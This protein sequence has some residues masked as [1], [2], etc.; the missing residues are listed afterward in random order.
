MTVNERGFM[1]Y[2]RFRTREMDD[3][4]KDVTTAVDATDYQEDKGKLW[5]ESFDGE[6]D[7]KEKG[8]S[9]VGIDVTFNSGDIF[10]IPEHADQ[11]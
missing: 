5:E 3:L 9:S 7:T 4:R 8:P 2:E 6:T 1:N 11:F 10:G